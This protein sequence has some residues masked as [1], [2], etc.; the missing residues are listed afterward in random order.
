VT[1]RLRPALPQAV[2]ALVLMLV[3][4]GCGRAEP[5][6]TLPATEQPQQQT[7]PATHPTATARAPTRTPTPPEPT[8]TSAL[9]VLAGMG[10]LA[11][12]SDRDGNPDLY[13]M[14]ADGLG[15]TRIT[16]SPALESSLSASPDGQRIAFDLNDGNFDIYT[17]SRD[18]SGLSQVTDHLAWDLSPRWSSDG[19]EIVFA[20]QRDPI[21]GYEGP[22]PE[23]YLMSDIGSRQ[24]R[25]TR[26]FTSDT[27][28]ALSP[29]GQQ[30]VFVYAF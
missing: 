21:A 19:A 5:Q 1:R 13:I 25:V 15:L 10:H 11:F 20:S 3:A 30:I 23:I 2:L 12:G 7:P 28:P 8:P 4:L 6:A 27:C 9:S 18:G 29:D 16:D 14:R 17:I 26:N 24:T 22:P